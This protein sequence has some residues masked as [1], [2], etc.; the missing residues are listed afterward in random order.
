MSMNIPKPKISVIIPALNEQDSIGLVIRDIPK[1]VADE[2]IVVDNGSTD[3]TVREAQGAGARVVRESQRGYG[4][5]CL[6]GIASAYEPDI[7]VFLDGDYSDYPG[8]MG[9]VVAPIAQG[10][11]DLVIGSRISG[12]DGKSVLPPQAYWG[13]MLATLLIRM[14]YGYSFTDLGPFRAIRCSALKQLDMQD[15]NFG[16]T[17]EMQIK[18]VKQGLSIMEVPVH[19][20]ARIGKSKVS[21]TLSGSINAGAKILYTVFSHIF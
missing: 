4:A 15:R 6:K 7:I 16:W 19:Y 5:A 2:I 10:T 14:L 21:G 3:N 8:E 20:R 12:G 11:A 13:N 1:D 9:L 17:I 18:A